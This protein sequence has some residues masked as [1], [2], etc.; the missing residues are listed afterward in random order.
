V[1]VREDALDRYRRLEI[2]QEQPLTG[3]ILDE[4][5]GLRV[6]HH[7][8]NLRLELRRLGQPTLGRGVEQLVVGNAGPQ[9]ERQPRGELEVAYLIRR[10]R[11]DALGVTLDAEQELRRDEQALQREPNA[12]VEALALAG[13]L[14][15]KIQQWR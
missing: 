12:V 6:C 10:A 1:E 7:P 4:G 2:T 8:T 11:R 14:A 5:V 3:E 15:E 13:A 9:E